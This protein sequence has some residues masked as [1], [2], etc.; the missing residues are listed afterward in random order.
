MCREISD[1]AGVGICDGALSTCSS[2]FCI[3]SFWVSE[4]H[5]VFITLML[6]SKMLFHIMQYFRAENLGSGF[7][8]K[9]ALF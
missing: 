4:F 8:R 7:I 2:S 9:A 1:G 5:F 6:S 3:I